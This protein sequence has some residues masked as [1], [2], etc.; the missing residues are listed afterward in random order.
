MIWPD[1]RL[2]SGA[3]KDDMRHGQGVMRYPNK[4]S[5]SGLWEND[6]YVPN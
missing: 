2:Y 5:Q 6:K 1:G 4:T 3:F